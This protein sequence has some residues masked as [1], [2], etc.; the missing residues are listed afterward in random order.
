MFSDVGQDYTE[1]MAQHVGVGG[2]SESTLVL[3]ATIE[4]V[5]VPYADLNWLLTFPNVF[6]GHQACLIQYAII[7]GHAQTAIIAC[8]VVGMAVTGHSLDPY[9]LT[10]REFSALLHEGEIGLAKYQWQVE[11]LGC[12]SIEAKARRRRNGSDSRALTESG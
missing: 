2:V 6:E 11:R 1:V 12:A 5:A 9:V 10:T 8:Y 3:H 4:E 7:F